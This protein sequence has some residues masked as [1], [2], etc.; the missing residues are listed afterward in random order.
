VLVHG[1]PLRTLQIAADRRAVDIID[2]TALPHELVM[3]RLHTASDVAEAIQ[4]MRVRGAPLIGA[5]AAVGMALAVGADPSDHALGAAAANLAAARPTAVN[6]AWATAEVI[7][8]VRLRPPAERAALAWARADA[9]I[10]DDV[11]ACEAIAG[12]GAALIRRAWQ[13]RG[14]GRPVHIL[15]HCNAGWLATI[16]W[17]TALGP[18]YRAHRDGVPVHVFVEETRPRNQG[19]LTAWELGHEG[20]P[21]EIIV[22]NA[23]GHLLRR[24]EVDLVLVGSDRTTRHGDVCNKI[25]TYQKAVCA[26][27]AGVPFY[28]A[29]PHSTIDWV[30]DDADTIPIEERSADEITSVAG[31]DPDGQPH[32]VWVAPPGARVRN[33]GFDVTPARLVTALIT[34]R[35]VA[36]ASAAGLSA[37]YPERAAGNLR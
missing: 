26:R 32:V 19:M 11:A 5:A 4:T 22:D 3:R 8:A 30:T 36:P 18:I 23:G 2:Q 16:D 9:I 1:R 17:G 27:D 37:L 10:A 33:P 24:G 12:H 25:G 15:T 28:V 34:E 35:G 7:A 21:Y 29:L 13:A 6:L 14:A 20:V 31:R